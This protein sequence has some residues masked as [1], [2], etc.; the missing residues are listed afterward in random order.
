MLAVYLLRPLLKKAPSWITGM[1]W[2][3][4]AVR[5]LCPFS[6]ESALSLMPRAD[7]VSSA[8]SA[9]GAAGVSAENPNYAETAGEFLP[10]VLVAVWVIGAAAMCLY[11]AVSYI[12]LYCRLRVSVC[13]GDNVFLCDGARAPFIF[14]MFR[15]R[16]YLPSDIEEAQKEHILQ[17][18]YAHLARGDQFWKP[19][20]FFVLSVYWFHPLVWVSYVLFCKDIELACDARVARQ[21]TLAEKKAYSETLLACSVPSR[22]IAAC[23][24]SFAET[25]VKTRIKS[26][27]RYQK[28]TVFVAVL[29]TVAVAAVA[30]C[31]MTAPKNE[32]PVVLQ[33]EAVVPIT[34]LTTETPT[35][36][37]T[38]PVTQAVTEPTAENT[39]AALTAEPTTKKKKSKTTTTT[40]EPTT[41][42]DKSV[43]YMIEPPEI[44]PIE[45]PYSSNSSLLPTVRR[46]ETTNVLGPIVWDYA[47]DP[48]AAG[49][50]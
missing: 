49:R 33:D 40:A 42:R 31:L 44:E 5:L 7:T 27:L 47:N 9:N 17:H 4:C 32:P 18:E 22:K 25:S 41:Q 11:A 8:I 10:T 2:A 43:I 34:E 3:L 48:Y 6:V 36:P 29:S 16:I 13:D 20:G 24:L 30:V 15:P 28:P 46:E 35:E 37:V 19:L 21:M 39:T 23:P 26:V 12:R 45:V 14:G 50:R 38:E 1:A